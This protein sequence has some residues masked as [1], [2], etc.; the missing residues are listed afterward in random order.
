MEDVKGF[1]SKIVLLFSSQ[2]PTCASGPLL[3]SSRDHRK[4]VMTDTRAYHRGQKISRNVLPLHILNLNMYV[5]ASFLLD[6]KFLSWFPAA[7]PLCFFLCAFSGLPTSSPLITAS[8]PPSWAPSS[9]FTFIS[10]ARTFPGSAF[11][12]SKTGL[13]SAYLVLPT[14]NGGPIG[15]RCGFLAREN[16]VEI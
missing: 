7:A 3:T 6:S 14:S 4:L 15:C 5:F 10:L 12:T 2:I 16:F 9:H 11:P 8:S 13:A 1:Q